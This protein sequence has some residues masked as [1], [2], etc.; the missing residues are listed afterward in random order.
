MSNNSLK[1]LLCEELGL[2]HVVNSQLSEQTFI[3]HL[4]FLLGT[5][6]N[7]ESSSKSPPGIKKKRHVELDRWEMGKT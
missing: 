7:T 2:V 3:E 1:C 4:L 5:M 6:L